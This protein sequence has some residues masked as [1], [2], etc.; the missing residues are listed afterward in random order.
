MV[1]PIGSTFKRLVSLV[2]YP[3]TTEIDPSSK[4]GQFWDSAGERLYDLR[5]GFLGTDP[6]EIWIWNGDLPT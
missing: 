3:F 4:Y 2:L 6:V 5:A 1:L